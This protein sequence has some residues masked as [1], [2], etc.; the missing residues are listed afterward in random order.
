LSTGIVSSESVTAILG[1]FIGD[2]KWTMINATIRYL[3][4]Y[5]FQFGESQCFV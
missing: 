3:F 1:K 2:K 5:E 4:G